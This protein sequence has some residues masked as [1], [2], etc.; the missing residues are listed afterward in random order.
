MALIAQR[1][2]GNRLGRIELRAVERRPKPYPPP[3]RPRAVIREAVRVTAMRKISGKRH[4]NPIV[5]RSP[6]ATRASSRARIRHR[7]IRPGPRHHQPRR[8]CNAP[9]FR[10]SRAFG[11]GDRSSSVYLRHRAA[12]AFVM[13]FSAAAKKR[14]LTFCFQLK[15][16]RCYN[17]AEIKHAIHAAE[18]FSAT[19][20]GA[21]NDVDRTWHRR[22]ASAF[23]SIRDVVW[24]ISQRVTRATQWGSAG[25]RRAGCRQAGCPRAGTAG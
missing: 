14:E 17:R 20:S 21:S 5:L 24:S 4:S 1:R 3:T 16:S 7:S 2:V 12:L 19:I 25:C 8:R 15:I 10:S 6:G 23:R 9:C 22:I 11:P 18:N 13:R